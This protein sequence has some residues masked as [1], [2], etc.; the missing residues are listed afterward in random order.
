M[1]QNFKEAKQRTLGILIMRVSIKCIMLFTGMSISSSW[2]MESITNFSLAKKDMLL[3]KSDLISLKMARCQQLWFVLIRI[4]VLNSQ[5]TA[6]TKIIDINNV[7][8]KQESIISKDMNLSLSQNAIISSC[9][10]TLSF[11]N[12]PFGHLKMA[13]DSHCKML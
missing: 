13:P 7:Y 10:M 5:T 8:L 3:L 12:S 6:A 9:S 2:T 1:N 4:K 11:N